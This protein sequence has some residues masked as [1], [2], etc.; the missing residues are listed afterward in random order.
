MPQKIAIRKESFD[1]DAAL[2]H[3]RGD[4]GAFKENARSFLRGCSGRMAEI[5][6]AISCRNGKR[7]ERA[8]YR[9]DWLLS[10]LGAAAAFDAALRLE[11]LG[12]EGDLTGAEEAYAKLESEIERLKGCLQSSLMNRTPE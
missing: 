7:L 11:K 1:R 10:T 8:A 3:F 12:R 4:V 2:E 6:E 9:L 5:R